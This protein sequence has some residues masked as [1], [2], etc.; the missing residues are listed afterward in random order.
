MELLGQRSTSLRAVSTLLAYRDRTEQGPDD[1]CF[2]MP[3][4]EHRDR[5][6]ASPSRFRS[7]ANRGRSC[8]RPTTHRVVLPASPYDC[9][10]AADQGSR[11]STCAHPA[12]SL[13][14]G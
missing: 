6:Q 8:W 14:G 12:L 5:E 7:V 2:L 10:S 9:P 4:V 13:G 11:R 1:R 3:C